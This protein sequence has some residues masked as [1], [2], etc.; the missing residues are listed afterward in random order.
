MPRKEWDNMKNL[1]ELNKVLND[2]EMMIYMYAYMTSLDNY[3]ISRRMNI[4]IYQVSK[5]LKRINKVLGFDNTF[6]DVLLDDKDYE[7]IV[8]L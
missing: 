6:T 8:A 7:E 2:E 1:F 3:E 5:C 4:S